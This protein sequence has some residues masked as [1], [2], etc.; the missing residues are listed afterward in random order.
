MSVNVFSTKVL[1]WDTIFTSPTGDVTAILRGH[2]SP[3]RSS[4][5]QGKGHYISLF[6]L[7]SVSLIH[8]HVLSTPLSAAALL[9]PQL[10]N[11]DPF[12]PPN[13]QDVP[14]RHFLITTCNLCFISSVNSRVSAPYKSSAF[15]VT[16]T[17]RLSP[18]PSFH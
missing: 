10:L 9:L 1:I 7:L 8:A 13:P 17:Q 3:R 14:N 16:L 2:P 18:G 5:L 15:T 4:H 11:S 6:S 12:R